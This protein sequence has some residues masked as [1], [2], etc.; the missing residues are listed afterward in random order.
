MWGEISESIQTLSTYLIPDPIMI[1]IKD[2]FDS[3]GISLRYYD[4]SQKNYKK[5]FYSIV[6]KYNSEV[7]LIRRYPRK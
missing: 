7:R 3:N 1:Q 4:L 5:I 2:G 6:Y